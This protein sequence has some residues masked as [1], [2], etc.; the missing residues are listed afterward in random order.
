MGVESTSKFENTRH[1]VLVNMLR[2]EN[3]VLR[4]QIVTHDFPPYGREEAEGC[5]ICL[6]GRSKV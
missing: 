5:K 3:R 1:L 6:S 2:T 4:L